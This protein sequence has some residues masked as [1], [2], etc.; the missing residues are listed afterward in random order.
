MCVAQ[1][2]RF[3]R[4]ANWSSHA[5]RASRSRSELR[6]LDLDVD[7]LRLLIL[8]Y[9]HLALRRVGPRRWRVARRRRHHRREP[10]RHQPRLVRRQAL[11]R[12]AN[13]R[14][15]RARAV[16]SWRLLR[17]KRP[18]DPQRRSRQLRGG[19]AV[20][21]QRASTS[22]YSRERNACTYATHGMLAHV[23][24]CRIEC[25]HVKLCM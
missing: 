4:N 10:R 24:M 14:S 22:L 9:L 20:Q 25:G 2:L 21:L 7:L 6:H 8:R 13:H 18:L 11:R 17:M 23:I 5:R 3:R 1:L 12:A 15:G 19:Q 16:P